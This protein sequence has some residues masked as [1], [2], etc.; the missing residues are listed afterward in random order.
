MVVLCFQKR[1]NSQPKVQ[2]EMSMVGCSGQICFDLIDVRVEIG[3][4]H[5]GKTRRMD[6]GLPFDDGE[7]RER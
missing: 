7:L 2:R 4:S 1:K 3:I 5:V 6:V